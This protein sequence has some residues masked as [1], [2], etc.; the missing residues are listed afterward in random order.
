[1]GYKSYSDE[2]NKKIENNM[3]KALKAIG[4]YVEGEAKI[5]CPVG[6]YPN[7][8]RVGGNLR[9]SIDHKVNKR[10]KSAIIGTYVNYAIC[11]EKGTVKMRPQPYLEPET[12]EGDNNI[13]RIV[14]RAL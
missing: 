9:S 8:P 4:L 13:E 1:M 2:V 11:V 14:R 3:N 10:G 12:V 5:R 6:E 7:S